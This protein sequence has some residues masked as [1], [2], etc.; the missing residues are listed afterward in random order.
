MMSNV[1]TPARRNRIGSVVF[2]FA[3]VSVALAASVPALAATQV[4][5]SGAV[6]GLVTDSAGMPQPGASVSLF[7]QQSHLLQRAY[8]DLTGNFSFGDLLPDLYAVQV[9]LASFIPATRD[10]VQV[11]PG[12]RSLLEVSLSR[13]FSS[14][15]IVSIIPA[16]GGLMSDDWKWT[17]RADSSLRPV[18]RI[19]PADPAKPASNSGGGNAAGTRVAVF[20]NSSA[21]VR[22]SASDGA[23]AQASTG[24][25]DLGTQFAF[26][27]SVYAGNLVQVSGN[28][29]YVAASGTPAAAIRTTFS[30]QIAGDTP[31]V[32]V[33]MREMNM[34]MR[35][36]QAFI[37]SPADSSQPA[38]RSLSIS[39]SDRARLSDA[40]TVE[41]GSELDSISFIDKLQYFSPWARLNYS[42]PRGRLDL[43][44]TSGNARPGLAS[45]VPFSSDTK[46]SLQNELAAVALLPRLSQRDGHVRVQRGDDYEVGYSDS[47][48]ATEI[49]VSGYHQYVANA[50][51]T[52]ANP[53]GDLFNGDLLPSMFTSSALFNV[54][55]VSTTGYTVSATRN[56]GQNYKVTAAY[57]LLGVMTPPADADVKD[58]DSLRRMIRTDQRRAFTL[59]ASGTIRRTGTSFV[60]SYQF[61]D[62]NATVPIPSYSTQPD[63]SDPGLNFAF[64]QPVPFIP[65]MGRMEATAEI[66]NLLAQGYLPLSMSNGRQMLIVN[67]PRVLRGGLA[68]VF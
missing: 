65:G 7:N 44:F 8:T 2:G 52:I 43:V 14:I 41:Y 59:R 18:L 28:L 40:L 45:G 15:Q 61:A 38:L 64:R 57:G 55:T 48:G 10:R 36:G 32:S 9:S 26:A 67:T 27:T 50:T 11:K 56:L 17:L 68:F 51:L 1:N 3:V 24:E 37:G 39:L 54:G 22:I 53:E 34:P 13:M 31:T 58:A 33:T 66:R 62:L 60:G 5:F 35:V 29:G 21:L 25:A 20:H 4:R 12:M 42:L 49:R 23:Q 63:R 6:S 46:D 19:L 30:R 16:P 47:I